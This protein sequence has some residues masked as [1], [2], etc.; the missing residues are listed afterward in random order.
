MRRLLVRVPASTSN[1]GPG[2]D[3]L[4]L[5][6][7]LWLEVELELD[8]AG[9]S[10]R[11]AVPGHWPDPDRDL[12]LSAFERAGGDR[13]A[14][15]S[16]RVSTEIPL[17]RGLGSS[18]AAVAAGLLLGRASVGDFEPDRH[19]LLRAGIELEGHPDNVAAALFGGCTLCVP[20]PSDPPPLL[21]V[22][23]H[24]ALGFVAAWPEQPL[25]TAQARAVLPATVPFADAVENARR[26]PLLLEGLRRGDA[27]LLRH[28]SRDRLHL[29]YRL[30]LLPGAER[31]LAAAEAAGAYLATI[32]GSGSA[33]FA[34]CARDR[35]AAVAQALAAPLR[36]ARG[37][38][39]A[40]ALEAVRDA[41]RVELRAG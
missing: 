12:V 19:H 1:L 6:L 20:L 4:G 29:P 5:C 41:P 18:G 39:E 2:F 23:V 14:L 7:S 10:C 21:P 24:P 35:R 26:L 15:R 3:Q 38:A 9:G 25:P 28:G 16:Y 8:V 22:E 32:S 30:P 17:M 40:R 34:A 33:L 11:R 37:H 13:R 36:A 27:G 31:A